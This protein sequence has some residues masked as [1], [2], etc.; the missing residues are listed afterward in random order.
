MIKTGMTEKKN[1][2]F[3]VDDHPAI[4]EGLIKLINSEKDFS[5]C[6]EAGD[7][8][9]AMRS[10]M[11]CGPDIVIVDL[12]LKNE[13][14]IR[15]IENLVYVDNKLPVIVY[16]M[17]TES[18]YAE[19]CLKAGAKGYVMKEES[20]EILLSALRTVLNGKI[21]LGSEIH[22]MLLKK[23]RKREGD[24]FRFHVELLSNRE[25]EVYQLTGNGLNA[26]EIAEKLNLGLKTIENYIKK[27][28]TKLKLRNSREVIIH[29]VK[30]FNDTV[31]PPPSL[32]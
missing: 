31:C 26:R 23:F 8:T 24:V 5:V 3:I 10:I 2:V 9:T 17:H 16:S 6:G 32:K 18:V 21:H 20:P 28:K 11:D 7:I 14:G 25:L 22:N 15:L 13:S 29:S 30:H 27:I 19:K 1:K 12:T 4:R